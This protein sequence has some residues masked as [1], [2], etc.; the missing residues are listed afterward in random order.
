MR[1]SNKFLQSYRGTA[2]LPQYDRATV[3]PG[4]LHIG[5]GAF[6]RAH[7]AVYIDSLL[8]K[9][10]EWGLIGVSMQNANTRDALAP[11]DG[12]YSVGIREAGD[13]SVRVIG[14]LM[15]I[16]QGGDA[17]IA[18]ISDPRIR[19]ITLTVTEKGYVN[20]G[21]IN[22]LGQT[23]VAGLAA[24]A[25]NGAPPISILSCDNL[26][27]NGAR[28]K[29][30]VVATAQLQAPEILR[31]LEQ[32]V[33]FPSSMVDR[34]TPATNDTDR[35]DIQT[36]TGFEDAWPV[37]TEPFSQWV[38]EDKFAAE[39][40]DFQSVGAEV[41]D[42]LAP[43]ESMKLRLLNG[44][45]TTMATLGPMLDCK[46]VSEAALDP[47]LAA[48]IERTAKTEVFPTLTQPNDELNSYWLSLMERFR[49]TSMQHALA[50]IA[51]DSS[52]KVPVRLVPPIIENMN[53]GRPA[54]GLTL[55]IAGWIASIRQ[56]ERQ[57]KQIF[58]P[59]AQILKNIANLSVTE[60]IAFLCAPGA[61]LDTLRE[62]EAVQRDLAKHVGS[63]ESNGARST[64]QQTLSEL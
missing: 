40:P 45:H 58:D 53:A 32:S 9:S 47:D 19:L 17:A 15:S 28:T 62:M 52:Q 59:N 25:Q 46:Y 35:I 36:M 6:H 44:A 31:Y 7:Q 39:R 23:L 43:F 16:Q 2:T 12:L 41:V 38:I 33:S 55:A 54:P 64:I 50:Q 5:V 27:D 29:A 24:R 57:G 37:I 42:D 56:A 14:S 13:M 34:I 49:N 30:L 26:P 11:Q 1:L 20:V 51:Q 18:A 21:N 61:Q 60:M 48:L 63:I 10:P 4:I 8:K 22:A 3:A